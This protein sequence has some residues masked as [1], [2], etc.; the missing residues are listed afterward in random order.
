M[1]TCLHYRIGIFKYAGSVGRCRRSDGSCSTNLCYIKLSR[2]KYG[3]T[4]S[5][6]VLDT[7]KRLEIFHGFKCD[8]EQVFSYKFGAL[9]EGHDFGL[10]VVCGLYGARAPHF[11]GHI[12][13]Y[14]LR[15]PALVCTAAH[16]WVRANPCYGHVLELCSHASV[17]ELFEWLE[18][19][20]STRF[21]KLPCTWCELATWSVDY[22]HDRSG[23]GWDFVYYDA[24]TRTKINA[25]TA[26]LRA[27]TTHFVRN[28]M[29][30]GWFYD[31]NNGPWAVWDRTQDYVPIEVSQEYVSPCQQYDDPNAIIVGDNVIYWT[32]METI[33]PDGSDWIASDNDAVIIRMF[34]EDAGV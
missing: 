9:I 19:I 20:D 26:K 14:T 2:R 31:E 23:T 25:Q 13:F 28:D 30:I 27:A 6:R 16:H 8:Q 5:V 4:C 17:R 29:P 7:Y 22:H 21:D 3:F 18:L 32:Y 34:L 12:N 33:A 11:L 1:N 10:W 15:V 24:W